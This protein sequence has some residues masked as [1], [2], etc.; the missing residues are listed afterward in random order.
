V[1]P[2]LSCVLLMTS[3]K[4]GHLLQMMAALHDNIVCDWPKHIPN[5]IFHV[6]FR[7]LSK[8]LNVYWKT[9]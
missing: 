3:C 9:F 5:A 4:V 1:K 7:K 6:N 8:K 2:T